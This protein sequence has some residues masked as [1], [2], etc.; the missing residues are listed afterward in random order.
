[1]DASPVAAKEG[2][3][4]ADDGGDYGSDQRGSDSE[5][6]YNTDSDSEMEEGERP[7]VIISRLSCVFSVPM[8]SGASGRMLAYLSPQPLMR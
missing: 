5:Y 6:D 4:G 8:N 3:L 2:H 1:M 7:K